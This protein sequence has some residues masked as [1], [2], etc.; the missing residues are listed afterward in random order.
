MFK[1]LGRSC[2][3]L[4]M[5]TLPSTALCETG[6]ETYAYGVDGAQVLDL[7]FPI[8]RPSARL[9][10]YVL[11]HGGLWQGSNRRSL[12]I[13]CRNVIEQSGDRVACASIDFRLS[14]DIGG[15]CTGTGIPAYREQIA[16]FAAALAFLQRNAAALGLD[17]YRA[18]IGGHSSGAH[19]AQVLNLRWD[20]FAAP[21]AADG[22]CPPPLG[23]IGIAGIYDIPGWDAWDEVFWNDAY[24][25]ATRQAFGAPGP[26]PAACTEAESGLRCWDA[27]SPLFLAQNAGPLGIRP[28]AGALLV[29]SPGDDWVDRHD[30]PELGQAL[31]DTS[32]DL[33]V[34]VD[35]TGT[36]GTSGHTEVLGEPALGACMAGY[37]EALFETAPGF[38][39]NAGISDAWY[40]PVT[41]GQGFFVTVWEETG[42]LF[43]A[44]FTYDSERP[45]ADVRARL[46]EPGHRWYTAQGPFSGDTAELDLYLSAG[47][48]FDAVSP[49]AEAAVSVGSLRLRFSGCNAGIASYELRGAGLAGEIPIQR[50]VADNMALCE[51]GRNAVAD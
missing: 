39:I 12:E 18:F 4:A 6:M 17:P 46:G 28:R 50:I 49:P 5:A 43:V 44:W 23:T 19:L 20:E 30:T 1:T 8:P 47:G 7:Y 35:T 48:V 37:A 16:D 34:V 27:G 36:C 22:S 41:S 24:N 21:C 38:R 26:E 32:V 3:L 42:E 11:A 29:H 13:L 2:C 14:F 25:C 10:V 31:L 33:A 51:A 45:P 15:Q 40:S 9:P